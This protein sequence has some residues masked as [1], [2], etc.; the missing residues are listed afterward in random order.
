MDIA[1]IMTKVLGSVPKSEVEL[2]SFPSFDS[3]HAN[4][5][6]K[7]TIAASCADTYA[8]LGKTVASP[9]WDPAHGAYAVHQEV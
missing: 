2:S 7:T 4:C 3:L 5:A 8:T 9:T 1:D 6:M